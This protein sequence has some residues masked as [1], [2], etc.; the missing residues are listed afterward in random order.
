MVHTGS[1]LVPLSIL[2]LRTGGGLMGF[3]M[4]PI[5]PEDEETFD[6][7]T[8]TCPE[9]WRPSKFGKK[10][11]SSDTFYYD[12]SDAQEAQDA[13]GY[14]A[15]LNHMSHVSH[16]DSNN[17]YDRHNDRHNDFD[18]SSVTSPVIE[19]HILAPSTWHRVIHKDIPPKLLR[20]YLGWRPLSVVRKTL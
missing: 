2:T 17:D 3:E 9:K 5:E 19:F 7:F 10:N 20:P 16:N 18:M 4:L 14:P 12:P 13:D 8:I 1:K 11:D 6:M 15:M